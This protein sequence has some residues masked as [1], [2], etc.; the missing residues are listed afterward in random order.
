MDRGAVSQVQNLSAP[1]PWSVIQ[2]LVPPCTTPRSIGL[3][4]LGTPPCGSEVDK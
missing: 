2:G 3:L 1:N 4:T